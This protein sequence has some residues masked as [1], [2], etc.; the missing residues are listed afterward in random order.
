M[1]LIERESTSTTPWSGAMEPSS[2]FLKSWLQSQM[3][4][5][6][7]MNYNHLWFA[8]P[9]L[10]SLWEDFFLWR[11]KGLSWKFSNC[12]DPSEHLYR[13]YFQFNDCNHWMGI[14]TIIFSDFFGR[15]RGTGKKK[16]NKRNSPLTPQIF[17]SHF[18]SNH[19]II[20]SDCNH[21]EFNSIQLVFS[22][23]EYNHRGSLGE[24]TN[25]CRSS[26][27]EYLPW[28]NSRRRMLPIVSSAD[29]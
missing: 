17:N 20:Q 28:T 19:L 29:M 6:V 22:Y 1:I 18:I 14:I 2:C 25:F 3:I 8:L 4:L 27:S 26:E 21:F 11:S 16:R 23:F 12:F 24:L 13:N 7:I 10:Q 15:R 5:L 9:W